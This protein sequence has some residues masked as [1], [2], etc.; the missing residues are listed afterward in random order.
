MLAAQKASAGVHLLEGRLRIL[1][2][3]SRR[4]E[5]VWLSMLPIDRQIRILDLH[6]VALPEPERHAG[7]SRSCR[8]R[9][10]TRTRPGAAAPRC[11]RCRGSSRN[12]AGNGGCN[13]GRCPRHS[14]SMLLIDRASS[15]LQ[16]CGEHTQCRAARGAARAG[17]CRSDRRAASRCTRTARRPYRAL[18]G[19]PARES[20]RP[21][22]RG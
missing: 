14:V 13:A 15:W 8:P 10:G 11:C 9:S 19:L 21:P 22:W 5:E 17:R 2:L 3:P 7:P 4:V 16:P 12:P 1:G 20:C 18:S 6:P